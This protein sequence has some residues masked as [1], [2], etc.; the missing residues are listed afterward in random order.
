MIGFADEIEDGSRVETD[1]CIVGGGPAGLAIALALDGAPFRVTVLESGGYARQPEV[2]QLYRGDSVGRPYFELDDCRQRYFGGSSN[3]W[4][5]LCRPLDA[6]DFE[7]RDWVPHSGWPF[8]RSELE[9]WYREAETL[10]ELRGPAWDAPSWT[11]PAELPS[12]SPDA[13]SAPSVPW[14]VTD[15]RVRAGFFKLSPPTR[16]GRVY[17]EPLERSANVRVVLGA[18]VARIGLAA[19]GRRVERLDVRR[20][21]GAGGFTV[22][23]RRYVIACGGIETPRLLLASDDVH[24]SGVGNDHDLVGRFFMEHP[25]TDGEAVV[26]GSPAAPPP[27][28]YGRHPR[29]DQLVW[30]HF[31][32]TGAARAEERLLHAAMVFLPYRRE[33]GL[34]ARALWRTVADTDA[35]ELP[36]GERPMVFTFG[37][38]SEQ[39]PNP[40]S[41]VR[42]GDGKDRLGMP[43]AVLDWRLTEQDVASVARTHEILAEGL[44]ASGM[45]RVQLTLA[46]GPRFPDHM[47]GGRHHMGTARMHPDPRQGVTDADGRVHGVDDLFVAGSALFPTSGSANPTLTLVALALRQAVRL[48]EELSA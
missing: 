11:A 34:F 16:F 31:Q 28:F 6:E 39:A 23:A 47:K 29:N 36:P 32:L 12:P 33:L 30:G 46:P 42:L 37:T 13:P 48:R 22:A 2:Q 45:A 5:G 24:P 4:T 41:R 43:R 27:F 18:S 21:T 9:P 44:A 26:L 7:A 8:P 38:P 19:N 20:S 35:P 3:C 10:L 17:K 40:Q 25:H 15:P 14:P 1:L